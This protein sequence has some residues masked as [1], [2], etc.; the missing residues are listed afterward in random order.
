MSAIPPIIAYRTPPPLRPGRLP[1]NIAAVACAHVATGGIAVLLARPYLDEMQADTFAPLLLS[2]TFTMMIAPVVAGGAVLIGQQ[3][4]LARLVA[5]VFTLPL[6]VAELLF[7]LY[8]LLTV[9]A[10]ALLA[11]PHRLTRGIVIVLVATVLLGLTKALIR[12]IATP[13]DP[14]TAILPS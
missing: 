14:P 3:R 11:A 10:G 6:F 2:W 8:G 1:W 5:A 12:Y 7:G 13:C 4:F 9:A